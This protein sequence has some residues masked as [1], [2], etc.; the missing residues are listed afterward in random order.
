MFPGSSKMGGECFA[1]PDVCKTPAPPGSPV[2][3]AYPNTGMCMQATKASSK[4]KFMGKEVLT[5]KSEIPRSMGDEPGIA[6]GLVSNRNMDKITFK[7]GSAKVKAEGTPV[8]TLTSLT[9]QNGMNA[10]MPS[11][12]QVAPSQ[13]K[14]LI[15]P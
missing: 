2:P 15:G 6:G 13:T 7:K 11:G 1:F 12:N 4:V 3:V 10:N 9:G 8:V 14:V 5:T